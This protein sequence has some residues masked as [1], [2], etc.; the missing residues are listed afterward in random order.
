MAAITVL[1]LTND[2]S[3]QK[4]LNEN[5]K[6]AGYSVELAGNPYQAKEKIKTESINLIIIDDDAFSD[7]KYIYY[8]KKIKHQVP[9]IIMITPDKS[10]PVHILLKNGSIENCIFKPFLHQSLLILVTN[11]INKNNRRLKKVGNTGLKNPYA[12]GKRK[13]IRSSVPIET[14]RTKKSYDLPVVI[15]EKNNLT[16]IIREL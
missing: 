11:V 1:L 3:I 15:E 8:L 7:A 4:T 12:D 10:S 2:T 13:I 9:V 6:L 14:S 16:R 5:M